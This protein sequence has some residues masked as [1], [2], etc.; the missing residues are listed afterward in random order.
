MKPNTDNK[1]SECCG[2]ERFRLLLQDSLPEQ[3]EDEVVAHLESCDACCDQLEQ[4]AADR[5]WWSRAT[6][7]LQLR[8]GE[9]AAHAF[10]ELSPP[11]TNGAHPFVDVAC[12]D[13]VASEADESF[14]ADFAVSYLEP[15]DKPGSLGRLGDF[16]LR[17]VIGRSAMGVV[18][19][20]IQPELNRLVAVKVMAPHLASSGAA[21]KRFAREAQAAAAI[22]HPHVMPIHAVNA[23]G[24]LPYLVMPYVAG[25]S[26]QQRL[27]RDG[28]LGLADIL[29]IGLQTAEALAAAH[30]QGL[31]HRD[32]KPGNILLEKGV[33][34]VLL[35]DFGLARAVDDASLTRTGVIAGTP[36]FMSPEQAAGDA[37]D[38]RSDLFSLGSVLYSMAAGRPP[39]RSETTFGVLRRIREVQPRSIGQVNPDIPA[40]LQRLIARLH[41]KEPGERF[42]SAADVAHLLEQCLAH[43]QQPTVSPLPPAL[44]EPKATPIS[45]FRRS[46]F[47][48]VIAIFFT[49]GCGLLGMLAWE[50]THRLDDG[51]GQGATTSNAIPK[52]TKEERSNSLSEEQT[53]TESAE[54][55]SLPWTED[56]NERLRTLREATEELKARTSKSWGGDQLPPA[57]SDIHHANNQEPSQ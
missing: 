20:G 45:K 28:P 47:K 7:I 36:Q 49:L 8:E 19:K 39:F 10:G 51:A 56:L 22:V 16:E 53:A 43:V 11:T 46:Y 57:N 2:E 12:S 33:N 52:I 40:W 30:A 38:H 31:V 1:C 3:I 44:L 26:L 34:R 9:L 18:L 32:V 23:T 48:G 5:R 27:D 15:S 50:T 24:K 25:E 35:A 37:I 55:S 14:A 4:L 29:R 13:A 54:P 42:Q 17:E 6:S 41:A 21:R